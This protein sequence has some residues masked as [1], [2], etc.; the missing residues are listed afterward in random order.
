MRTKK[1]VIDIY[2]QIDPAVYT[3]ERF[4]TPAG[5]LIDGAEKDSVKKLLLDF[6]RPDEKFFLLDAACGPGRLSSYLK[7]CFPKAQITGVDINDNMLAAARKNKT[8]F[9]KGDLYNLPFNNETFDVVCGLRFSMHMADLPTVLK[10]LTRVVKKNGVL[11]FDIFN[12]KSILLM[13]PGDCHYYTLE[14]IKKMA[15]NC[16]LR[17]F[18]YKGIILLGETVLRKFL[19][20]SI[21]V[22]PP[23][24]LQ[25]LAS[26]LVVGL[27]KD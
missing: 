11:I 1:Q 9:V 3:Q 22:S 15:R 12:K 26:K 23:R 2:H 27:R 21:F 20:A 25:S 18:E 6:R 14:E 17:F 10:E 19:P 8:R 7:T 24:I 5:R 13:K 16:G 4:L